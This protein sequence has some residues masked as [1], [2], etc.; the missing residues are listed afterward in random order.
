[1]VYCLWGVAVTTKERV[2]I[3]IGSRDGEPEKIVLAFTE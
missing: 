1:M 2:G 3:Q